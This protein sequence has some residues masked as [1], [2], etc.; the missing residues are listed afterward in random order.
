MKRCFIAF[1][2]FAALALPVSAQVF[3]QPRFVGPDGQKKV[4]DYV[5]V[6]H[7]ATISKDSGREVEA[8]CPVNYVV[9]SGGYTESRPFAV[10]ATTPTQGFDGWVVD[11]FASY[12]G[13]NTVTVYAG[14]ASAK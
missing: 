3:A 2:A 6:W 7:S 5:W 13:S 12:S 9:I 11:A 8:D 14:C 1:L 4:G 10:G